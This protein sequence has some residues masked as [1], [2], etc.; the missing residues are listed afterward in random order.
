MR[1]RIVAVVAGLALA[2]G[3]VAVSA[4]WGTFAAPDGG[5]SAV[6]GSLGQ[7][8]ND[9]NGADPTSA[10]TNDDPHGDFGQN[11]SMADGGIT[12]QHD[13]QTPAV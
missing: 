8:A 2:S 6:W 11:E 13:G 4:V 7:L 1:W 9:P 10:S 12:A 5:Y 3:G